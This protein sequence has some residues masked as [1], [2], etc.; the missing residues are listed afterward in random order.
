MHG[1]LGKNK[2]AKDLGQRK[3]DGGALE[4]AG[5]GLFENAK[6]VPPRKRLSWKAEVT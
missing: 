2:P 6:T 3:G 1:V 5:K 4:P